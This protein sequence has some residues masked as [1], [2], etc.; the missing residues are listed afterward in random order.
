M[1]E[2][3][4]NLCKS[5]LIQGW[6]VLQR[7]TESRGIAKTRPKNIPFLTKEKQQKRKE[8]EAGSQI[9]GEFFVGQTPWNE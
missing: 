2:S 6:C 4:R 1:I 9:I 3:D 8:A 7:L 5:T